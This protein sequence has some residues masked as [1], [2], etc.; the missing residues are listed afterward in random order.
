MIE[1][2]D[3]AGGGR[4]GMLETKERRPVTQLFEAVHAWSESVS[5]SCAPAG[6]TP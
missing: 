6:L 4:G 1:K 3:G 2:A 5:A